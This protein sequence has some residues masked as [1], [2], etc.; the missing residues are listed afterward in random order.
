MLEA[1]SNWAAS[2]VRWHP[3]PPLRYIHERV[4]IPTLV[5]DV[6]RLTALQDHCQTKLGQI[7]GLQVKSDRTC[8]SH[9]EQS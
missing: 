6:A 8:N 9:V 5:N 7:V 3:V 2:P 1:I 4:P